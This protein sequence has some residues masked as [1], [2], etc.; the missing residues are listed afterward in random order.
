M[1]VQI[2]DTA[3]QTK[4]GKKWSEWFRILN[5]AGAREMTHQEIVAFLAKKHKVGPWWQQM[6]TVTYEK[7]HGLREDYQRPEGHSIS[8][9]K[10]IPV[11]V[12]TLFKAWKNERTRRLW[13]KEKP[14]TIRKATLNKSLRITWID[15][16]T[17]L[18]VNLYSKGTNKSQVVVQHS[19][20]KD[21]KE[22][23]KMIGYWAKRLEKLN[24]E[25]V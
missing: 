23:G 10:T 22:A 3:V 11:P 9:S 1:P 8:L 18:E 25:L 15:G 6:V 17:N 13:L 24:R 19:K 16:R 4:T 2:G 12:S 20:L 14:L 7:S 21:S 5:K